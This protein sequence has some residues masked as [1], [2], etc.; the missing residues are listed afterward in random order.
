MQEKKIRIQYKLIPEKSTFGI[1]F[2]TPESEK[3]F[4]VL[5][6]RE[7]ITELGGE[8]GKEILLWNENKEKYKVKIQKEGLS[9]S[10]REQIHEFFPYVPV[11]TSVKCFVELFHKYNH[12]KNFRDYEE[13]THIKNV[14]KG[15]E[16]KPDGIWK[17]C[18]LPSGEECLW[19]KWIDEKNAEHI[20]VINSV[21][22]AS[23]LS[24]SEIKE[25]EYL[26]EGTLQM[27]GL[28]QFAE[29][30]TGLK[31]YLDGKGKKVFCFLTAEAA[32]ESAR[33]SLGSAGLGKL[34]DHFERYVKID[35][36]QM[37]PRKIFGVPMNVLRACNAGEDE[38]L[39]YPEERQ[40]LKEACME[41]VSI[42]LQPFTTISAMWIRH[43][44]GENFWYQ[45][46]GQMNL[47][48]T[49]R[50]LNEKVEQHEGNNPFVVFVT[51]YNYLMYSRKIGY[52][53]GVY[54]DNLQEAEAQAA[55]RINAVAER[56]REAA[57]IEAVN[58]TAYR[59]FEEKDTKYP[60]QVIAPKNLQELR[61]LERNEHIYV[62]SCGTPIKDR[63]MYLYFLK[64][65]DGAVKWAFEI[66]WGKI[67]SIDSW[68][69]K[70]STEEE[71]AY[72]R[73]YAKRKGVQWIY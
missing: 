30:C 69:Y 33:A 42:F 70:K 60:Y 52:I 29:K 36:S 1:F 54:P 19:C 48:K 9:T 46:S 38:M 66:F 68:L 8:F 15:K 61:D 6:S 16:W 17:F 2:S 64:D 65:Q 44:F 59:Y 7:G 21:I 73:E 51:Y 26:I 25:Q 57:F 22:Y 10:D 35:K 11:F 56:E 24:F 63:E 39:F 20:L 62:R 37:D 53:Y 43:Y 58:R 28:K 45:G 31:E 3:E 32:N 50:Y 18:K 41:N 12:E 49:I 14:L 40:M 5:F 27:E 47:G 4:C 55:I 13:M 34:A 23:D 72:L 71:R 67:Q